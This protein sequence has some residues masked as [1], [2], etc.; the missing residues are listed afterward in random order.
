M[1]DNFEKNDI[2]PGTIKLVREDETR[3]E[4]EAKFREESGGAG[5]MLGHLQLK[6]TVNKSLSYIERYALELTEPYWPVLGVKMN[7]LQIEAAFSTPGRDATEPPQPRGVAFCRPCAAY[8]QR[9][10]PAAHLQRI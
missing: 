6:F 8:F 10:D 3:A 1:Q 4:F 9:R 5:Q 2:E 7:T